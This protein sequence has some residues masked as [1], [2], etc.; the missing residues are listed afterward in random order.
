MATIHRLEP[1]LEPRPAG[2]AAKPTGTADIIL[3]PGVRYERWSET[4]AY[5]APAPRR[6]KQ[7][8]RLEIAD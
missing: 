7:R 1:S 5:N 4:H 8:D 3:F 2:R 6:G